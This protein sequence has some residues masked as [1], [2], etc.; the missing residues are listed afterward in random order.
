MN[1]GIK[2]NSSMGQNATMGMGRN[3]F[4]VKAK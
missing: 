1:L 4:E 3:N 2:A